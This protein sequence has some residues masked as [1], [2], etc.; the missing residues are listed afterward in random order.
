V[1]W[2][3]REIGLTTLQYQTIENMIQAIG[4]PREKLCLHC[5]IGEKGTKQAA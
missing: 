2:I 4:L 3:R 1:D 5:W